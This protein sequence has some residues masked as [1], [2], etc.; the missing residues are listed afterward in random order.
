MRDA[1]SPLPPPAIT[2]PAM[3]PPARRS[4]AGQPRAQVAGQMDTTTTG[5]GG[6][7][8][9]IEIFYQFV[10]RKR[11]QQLHFR[12]RSI[13]RVREGSIGTGSPGL[14]SLAQFNDPVNNGP[15]IALAAEIGKGLFSIM[16]DLPS[17]D[18]LLARSSASGREQRSSATSSSTPASQ[19]QGLIRAT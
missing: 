13:R 8:G 4:P 6:S 9:I 19:A 11:G 2:F 7:A 14:I 10:V 16:D 5:F 15:A 12:L 3:F 1:S 18:V 17:T